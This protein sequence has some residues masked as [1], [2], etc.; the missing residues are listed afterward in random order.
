MEEKEYRRLADSL[1]K[2]I[3]AAFD[4]IDPDVAECDYSQG[5]VTIGFADGSKCILST[6]PSVRQIWLAAAS[7]GVGLHFGYEGA[8][9]TWKDDK[10]R[11]I[12]L[13]SYLSLLIRDMAHVTIEI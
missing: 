8:S 11:G 10:G 5:A 7:R 12:E 6:Q 1:F 9:G 2:R 4:E 3:G 13:V